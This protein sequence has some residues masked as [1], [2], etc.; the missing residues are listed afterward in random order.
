[1]MKAVIEV[2]RTEL[3]KSQS[4]ECDIFGEFQLYNKL[5]KNLT[6]GAVYG[7]FAL[8][9]EREKVALFEEAK[10]KG[11]ND[12]SSISNLIPI[13]NNIYPLYW[14]KDKRI[15]SR[16]N[17]HLTNPDGLEQGK[18]SGT[19]LIRLSAYKALIG[20]KLAVFSIVVSKYSCFEKELQKAYPP[21]LLTKKS[22]I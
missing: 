2:I 14:G 16:I 21:L 19:A 15:G 6:E 22:K 8:L 5:P 1:M 13:A 18:K 20:V 3:V 17:V 4:E 11:T 7:F 9:N 10:I 12:L